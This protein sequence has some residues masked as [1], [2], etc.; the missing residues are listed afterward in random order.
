MS[1]WKLGGVPLRSRLILGTGG[2]TN[3]EHLEAALVASGAEVATVSLRR[4]DPSAKG[5]SVLDLLHRLG[6]RLLPNTAGCYT[7]SEAVMTAQLAREA[8]DTD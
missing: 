7:A 3:L 8:F 2:A 4:V 6:L 1:E 5:S